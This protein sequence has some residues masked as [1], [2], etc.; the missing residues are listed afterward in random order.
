MARPILMKFLVFESLSGLDSQSAEQ[1]WSHLD[2]ITNHTEKQI[3]IK[4]W[5]II[6]R[7]ALRETCAIYL[8]D[9]L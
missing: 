3:I 4:Q 1:R 5:L 9:R 6:H 7:N 2:L 8:D